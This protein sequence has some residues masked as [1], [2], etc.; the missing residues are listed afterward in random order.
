MSEGQISLS[1]YET[2]EDVPHVPGS[3]GQCRIVKNADG[4]LFVAK[5]FTIFDPLIDENDYE[6]LMRKIMS[7]DHPSLVKTIGYSLENPDPSDFSPQLTVIT[8]YYPNGSLEAILNRAANGENVEK[9][10]NTTKD[11]IIVGL[12]KALK[13]LHSRDI[14]HGCLK[15]T[16]VLFN[17]NFEP[18]ISDYGYSSYFPN[19]FSTADLESIGNS[20]NYL[21]RD[22]FSGEFFDNQKAV[23]IYAL[24]LIIHEIVTGNR[25]FEGSSLTLK[26]P[27]IKEGFDL[28]LN[29]CPETLKPLISTC[30][31]SENERP[32]IEQIDKKLTE[33]SNAL[34]PDIDQSIISEY[35]NSI[36]TYENN[37]IQAQILSPKKLSP[38][39]TQPFKNIKAGISDTSNIE[40][41]KHYNSLSEEARQLLDASSSGDTKL[42][43]LIS[44]LFYKGNEGFPQDYEEAL[45]Y[46]KL[47]A[48]NNDSTGMH[49]YACYLSNGIGGP[50]NMKVASDMF[51]KSADSSTS[52]INSILAYAYMREKGYGSEF[53]NY[54]QA[55][56]YYKRAADMG[57]VEAKFHYFR[58]QRRSQLTKEDV[59]NIKEAADN[60]IID[61]QVQYGYCLMKGIGVDKDE[62]ESVKYYQ[63]A[64]EGNSPSSDAFCNLGYFYQNGIGGLEKDYE[65]AVEYYKKAAEM[66]NPIGVVNYGIMLRLGLGVEK[67]E[68]DST[69]LFK[70]AADMKNTAGMYYY[71]YALCKGIGVKVDQR[72][73]VEYFRQAA[74]DK[75]PFVKAV[76]AYGY[77]LENG[78]GG[79]KKDIKEADRYYG[80]AV[81]MG[82]ELAN[83]ALKR[84]R[85]K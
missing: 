65:K 43:N 34:L 73:G 83:E 35:V 49:I 55:Q 12:S 62:T 29:S 25:L 28:D 79:V 42:Y 18:V 9:W 10:N 69:E 26:L 51:K 53:P 1:D 72:V 47:S 85:G 11:K 30:I 7:I 33:S 36:T 14:I 84:I 60:G 16:N 50:R 44:L 46:A 48:Y 75:N 80:R 68:E 8:K 74:D 37:L 6:P 39:R 58:I 40:R 38:E 4:E 71:G 70:K 2:V 24:G 21:P 20:I 52:N 3:H 22:I 15:P 64:I 78:I 45:R 27:K 82:Y 67:N 5:Q 57:N 17:E 77:V 66:N 31:K 41:S 19:N 61:A 56:E 13:F 76:Y 59:L 23:D 81:K 54:S 63:M 32:A